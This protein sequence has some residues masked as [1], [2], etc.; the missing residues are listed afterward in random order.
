MASECYRPSVSSAAQ[1]RFASCFVLKEPVFACGTQGNHSGAALWQVLYKTILWGWITAVI[2]AVVQ[3][4][5]PVSVRWAKDDHVYISLEEEEEVWAA[6]ARGLPSAAKSAAS[7]R[8]AVFHWL[9]SCVHRKSCIS[10]MRA[11]AHAEPMSV[12]AIWYWWDANIMAHHSQAF[13]AF[14]N[15]HGNPYVPPEWR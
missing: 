13:V 15:K 11:T 7:A 2:T 9:M 5:P 14:A 3:C 10:H 1:D 6:A 8:S 4:C 12:S